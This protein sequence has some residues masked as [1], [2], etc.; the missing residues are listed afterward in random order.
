M[1][2]IRVTGDGSKKLESALKNIQGIAGKAGWVKEKHYENSDMT[3]AGAAALAESGSPTR[4]IPARPHAKPTIEEN[5]NTWT[6]IAENESKKVLDGKQTG[7]GL[8]EVLTLKVAGD[9]R[10][11]ITKIW[12]PPLSPKTIANR[13]RMKKNKKTVGNLNKPLIDTTQM[14]ESLTNTVERE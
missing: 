11:T 10:E 3:T 9:W 8:M 13:L 2:V 12:S 7:E 1:K 5:Q 14:I 4:N 6:R